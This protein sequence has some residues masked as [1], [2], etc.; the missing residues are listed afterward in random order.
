[1]SSQSDFVFSNSAD[2]LDP[3]LAISAIETVPTIVYVYDLKIERSIFQN[4]RFGEILGLSSDETMSWRSEWQRYMH[5]DDVQAM[6]PHL[7]RLKQLKPGEKHSWQYRMRDAEGEWRYFI[8]QDAVLKQDDAG[9]PWLIVGTAFDATEQKRGEEQRN[10]L[11]AEMRHRTRN[12]ATVIE[13]IGR[14]SLKPDDESA[15]AFFRTLMG[16]VRALLDADEIALASEARVAE[17]RAVVERTLAPFRCAALEVSGPPAQIP[18]SMAGSLALA[19]HELATNA[20]KYGALSPNG[21]RVSLMWRKDGQKLHIEWKEHCTRAVSPPR[22]RGF[23][24][25]LIHYAVPRKGDSGVK[26]DFEPDG[27]RCRIDVPVP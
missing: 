8:S 17:F 11:L 13:G 19:L 10:I 3:A 6:P 24:T 4:R 9:R 5:P 26:L 21:G 14:R 25:G 22:H 23:G 16:R 20:N 1:M 2:T 12:F 7:E 27:V 15:K 18:Q